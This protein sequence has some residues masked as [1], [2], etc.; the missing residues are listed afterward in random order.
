MKY[1][2]NEARESGVNLSWSD[3]QKLYNG[4]RKFG[5]SILNSQRL[6]IEQFSIGRAF[7]FSRSLENRT[8]RNRTRSTRQKAGK[9]WY[10]SVEGEGSSLFDELFV[11]WSVFAAS[12]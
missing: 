8:E 12:K 4:I 7:F 3:R 11:D 9:G 1:S 6:R 10:V 5:F 2:C